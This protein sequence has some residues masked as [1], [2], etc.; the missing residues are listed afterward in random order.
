MKYVHVASRASPIL[1]RADYT[2][3]IVRQV[4]IC[5]FSLISGL[6]QKRP[7]LD[8]LTGVAHEIDDYRSHYLAPYGKQMLVDSGGYSIITGDVVERDIS[9]FTECYHEYQA[10]AVQAY[11]Y[12]MTLD[13]PLIIGNDE[14]NTTQNIYQHNRQSLTATRENLINYPELREKLFF[15]WQFKTKEHFA[16]W[17][18]IISELDLNRY[19]KHRALGG[20]VSLRD[21]TGIDFSPFIANSFRC[22][23]DYETSPDPSDEFRL[24]LL[25]INIRYDRFI[26]AFLEKLFTRYMGGRGKAA[27]TYDSINY[28]RTAQLKMRYLEIYTFDDHQLSVFRDIPSVPDNILKRVYP[29]DLFDSIQEEISKIEGLYRVNDS[30]AFAPLNIFSNNEIDRYFEY[31][32]DQYELIDLLINH[33]NAINFKNRIRYVFDDLMGKHPYLFTPHLVQSIKKNLDITLDFHHWYVNKR[34][35]KTLNRK[36]YR[37][38]EKINFPTI[39]T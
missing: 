15:V 23:L 34:D 27:L 4:G 16:I 17:N 10:R 29:D 19:V 8:T 9:K 7:G 35:Y 21:I 2:N 5:L 30:S 22:F 6:N 39:L 18:R 20:M 31:I 13:I 1:G 11:D 3:A 12:I 32:I 24:H 25:G 14:F 37:F 36:I 38:I 28:S 33:K 26:I